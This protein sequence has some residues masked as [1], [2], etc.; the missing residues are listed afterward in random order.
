MDGEMMIKKIVFSLW[1][2]GMVACSSQD[3]SYPLYFQ[4]TLNDQ[5][6]LSFNVAIIMDDQAGLDEIEKKSAQVEY[7]M[8]IILSQRSLDQVA[9]PKRVKSVIRKICDSQVTHGV[10][11]MDITSMKLERYLGPS[12]Y[13]EVMY[14]GLVRKGMSR[15]G[16]TGQ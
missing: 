11:R 5:S 4:T 13:E 12:N 9:S 10:A 16:L 3:Y 2:L 15:K 14:R 8:R 1:F 7:G 6:I